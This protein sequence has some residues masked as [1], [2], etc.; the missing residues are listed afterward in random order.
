MVNT[1]TA[2]KASATPIAY[3]S[4]TL[5]Y[6]QALLTRRMTMINYM[7]NSYNE[8]A[9]YFIP[10]EYAFGLRRDPDEQGQMEL[11]DRRAAG[12]DEGSGRGNKQADMLRV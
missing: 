6:S 5:L 3:P 9:P 12:L 1:T 2:L 8:V 7:A 11:H 4:F 10:D